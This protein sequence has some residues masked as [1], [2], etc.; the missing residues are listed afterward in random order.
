MVLAAKVLL[1]TFSLAP[2]LLATVDTGDNPRGLC[3]LC[4]S[5]T[6]AVCLAPAPAAGHVLVIDCARPR[7]PPLVVAAHKTPLACVALSRDGA[8]MA[9]A[10]AQG[11][12]VRVFA[13]GTGR[14]VREVRRGG[15]A[16]RIACINFNADATKLCVSR[17]LTRVC[18]CLARSSHGRTPF[19]IARRM[20]ATQ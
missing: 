15:T 10:S 11:T 5:E 3:A 9:T 6:S 1:Y 7:A 12:L 8:L 14:L 20:P 13:T 4:A 19:N 16:A 2:H 18:L 17:S